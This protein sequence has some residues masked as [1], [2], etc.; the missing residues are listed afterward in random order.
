MPNVTSKAAKIHSNSVRFVDFLD[1]VSYINITLFYCLEC[2]LPC[3][4]N[5]ATMLL[6][7]PTYLF[8]KLDF[9]CTLDIFNR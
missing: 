1:I 2:Y 8:E 5:K 6:H 4:A 3:L 9:S 7:T